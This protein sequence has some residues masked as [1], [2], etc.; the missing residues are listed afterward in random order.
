MAE[1]PQD[2]KSDELHSD[3]DLLIDMVRDAKHDEQVVVRHA[4]SLKA[5]LDHLIH[6]GSASGA[7]SP[8]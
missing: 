6:K 4:E 3:L 7:G 1:A 5:K 8:E 2:T